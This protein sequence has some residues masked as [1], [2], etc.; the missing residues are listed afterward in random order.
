MVIRCS[1]RPGAIS[2][3]ITGASGNRAPRRSASYA[4]PAIS[5][6]AMIR[7]PIRHQIPGVPNN[8]NT[9]IVMIITMIRKFVPHRTCTVEKRSTRSGSSGSSCS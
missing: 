7:E 4:I 8:A 2:A 6:I 9:K 3:L 5:G 1:Q